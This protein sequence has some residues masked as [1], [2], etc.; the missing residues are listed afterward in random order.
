M[1]QA[2]VVEPL[3]HARAHLVTCTDDAM[4]LLRWLSTTTE[5]ALDTETT[6]LDHD[7][8]R[9]R[10][11]QVGDGMDGWAIDFERSAMLVDDIVKRF[12]GMYRMHNAPFDHSM[13][14]NGKIH[15]PTHRIKDT[16]LMAHVLDSTGSLALKNLSQRFVDPR[17]AAGQ[18]ALDDA[19]GGKGNWTW[20]TV[21]TTFGP[22]WQYA[23]LDTI[24][25]YRLCD[26]LEPRVM[27]DAPQ[28]YQL[29]MAV[30]WV[31]ERMA[32]KGAHV[33][34]DYTSKFADELSVYVDAVEVWCKEN[35]GLTPGSYAVAERLIAEGVK[36]TKLTDG[37]KYSLDK[38]VLSSVSHPL[39][40]AVLGRRQSQKIVSTYLRHYLEDSQRDGRVHPSINTVG[41]SAKN[42]FESGGAR[43]VRTGRMSMDGP[44]LQNVPIR[45]KEGKRIRNCFDVETDNVWIKCDFEQIEMRLFAHLARD[46]GL[47]AAFVEASKP[48]GTDFFVGLT[49]TIFADD[50]IGKDDIR[51]QH[52]KNSGYAKLYGA[53]V[54]QFARTAGI[55]T[56]AG[57]LDLVVASAFLTRFDQLYPGIRNFQH[58]VE[59]LA[60][61]RRRDEGEAYVRSP[62]TQRKH[63]ADEGREYALVNYEVQGA[64]GE[65][66]KMKMLEADQAGLGE[67]MTLP[68]HDEIDLEVPT[69]VMHDVIGTLSEV[70]ND[71]TLLSVP[72]RS[73]ISVGSRWGDVKDI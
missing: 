17:A 41:G 52:V 72:I 13:L 21:P 2:S 14:S 46:P 16:R 22:Y 53:G 26:Y 12:E 73:T 51:R 4:D 62:L 10:L 69:A 67:Y 6:G 71:D 44:N 39:A 38:E 42:P 27:I 20:A 48:G 43:G 5:I 40:Q 59:R 30:T 49:R 23:A 35:Y 36:L 32:R 11:V 60:N 28:S 65:I 47:I 3:H 45:T 64:A 70:M 9:A 19:I 15:I 8:D 31:C 61:E 34:R 33:D 50:T 29:E 57:D 7:T 1:T 68:V 56:E 54:E 66:L 58:E 18:Q 24:L 37:G 25:T 55:Y 63:I